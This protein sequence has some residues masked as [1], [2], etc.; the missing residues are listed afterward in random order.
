MVRRTGTLLLVSA[1]ALALPVGAAASPSQRRQALLER[2]ENTDALVRALADENM[3]VRRTAVRLLVRKTPVPADVL[4]AALTNSDVV[5]R[6]AAVRAACRASPRNREGLL[7]KAAAD[8]DAVVRRLAIVELIGMR[9]R[10][11]EITAILTVAQE[12]END[13]VRQLAVRAVWP[14]QRDTVSLR[15]RQ[16]YDHDVKVTQAIPLPKDGWRFRLDPK[17]EGHLRKWFTPGYD[18]SAWVDISIEQAWQKAGHQHTGVA[19]YRRT[20][21]LPPKPKHTAADIHFA[22]VDESAWVWVNGSYVGDHDVGP[23][24]WDKPFFLDIT[25]EAKWGQPNQITVR[26][27]NTR[28]AGGIWRPV[29]IDVLE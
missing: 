2:P 21:E 23:E 22:G 27:M 20:M 6:A 5:V 29:T 7:A 24:G 18:D 16:D 12:D 15:Q 26:A 17:R 9:P 14:F 13:G 8:A 10:T 19:W 11:P 28:V 4:S 1:I 25:N 3:V